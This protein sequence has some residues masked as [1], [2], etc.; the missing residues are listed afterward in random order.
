VRAQ[1][2]QRPVVLLVRHREPVPELGVGN[3]GLPF[4]AAGAVRHRRDAQHAGVVER[5]ERLRPARSGRRPPR[6]SR[7]G[8]RQQRAVGGGAG[9]GTPG[10]GPPAGNTGSRTCGGRRPGR[11]GAGRA[12]R[13]AAAGPRPRVEVT[14]LA[15]KLGRLEAVNKD[16][17]SK[18]W[19]N[20]HILGRP[21]TFR[22]AAMSAR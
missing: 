15:Q 20:L 3:L 13:G 14:G 1:L 16:L 21:D 8:G 4:E 12:G 7:H 22:A 19:A 9:R 5:E 2:R 17:Q 11:G 6:C 18:Y 10:C